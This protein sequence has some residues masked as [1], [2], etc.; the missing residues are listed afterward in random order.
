MGLPHD[1]TKA[2]EIMDRYFMKEQERAGL[3][4]KAVTR[5]KGILEAKGVPYVRTTDDP[6]F[7]DVQD[8]WC[9]GGSFKVYLS[10]SSSTGNAVPVTFFIETQLKR[11]KG[12][13]SPNGY[14][15]VKLGKMR[16]YVSREQ[17][18]L[19]IMAMY[20]GDEDVFYFKAVRSLYNYLDA[21]QKR[22]S[23]VA[24]SIMADFA[25]RFDPK[26]EHQERY[27]APVKTFGNPGYFTTS[28]GNNQ[29]IV[30]VEHFHPLYFTESELNKSLE[31]NQQYDPMWKLKQKTVSRIINRGE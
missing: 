17:S 29:G 15:K 21:V 3:K 23:S 14:F 11:Y 12:K 4:E 26:P 22:D 25:I 24:R 28:L 27:E 1:A 5:F 19:A 7:D 2:Q 16:Q 18:K 9:T 6:L 13:A 30:Y 10:S 31:T 20:F 8:K